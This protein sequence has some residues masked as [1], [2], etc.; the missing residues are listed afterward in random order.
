MCF[1]ETKLSGYRFNDCTMEWL[2]CRTAT[3]CRTVSAVPDGL[4]I[5]A[6]T[7]KMSGTSPHGIFIA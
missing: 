1:Y 2:L 3:A 4:Q 5:T 6:P 7:T